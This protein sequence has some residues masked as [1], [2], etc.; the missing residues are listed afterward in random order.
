MTDDIKSA[1][2]AA[3]QV[4]ADPMSASNSI[5]RKIALSL[6]SLASRAEKI[7]AETVDKGWI[8]DQLIEMLCSSPGLAGRHDVR[9]MALELW[10][11]R[12]LSQPKE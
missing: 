8:S 3:Q 7:E 1:V 4:L 5:V 10:E 12:N 2:E 11:R 9:C 6:V